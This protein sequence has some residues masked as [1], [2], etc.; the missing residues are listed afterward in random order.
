VVASLHRFLQEGGGPVVI[1]AVSG[2]E[3]LRCSFSQGS[4]S[5][6][7]L[8]PSSMDVAACRSDAE[9]GRLVPLGEATGSGPVLLVCDV[10]RLHKAS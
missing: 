7:L 8:L 5:C 9:L 3:M 4:R 1:E 6:T 10:N 2:D